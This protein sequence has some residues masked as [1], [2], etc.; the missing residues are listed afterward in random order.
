[1][2]TPSL[3]LAGNHI[4]A[5]LDT[6]A[7]LALTVL[8]MFAAGASGKADE[9]C[10]IRHGS[11]QVVCTA[12]LKSRH[13]DSPARCYG[14]PW[15]PIDSPNATQLHQNTSAKVR[16]RRM[17]AAPAWQ[18]IELLAG[19]VSECIEIVTAP[20]QASRPAASLQLGSPRSYCIVTF[21]NRA[22]PPSLS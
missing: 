10:A 7:I 9:R 17:R 1:M 21:S 20:R 6:G 15:K 18:R 14:S 13:A 2:N 4:K 5:T 11:L 22:P 3:G 19:P 16:S 12:R 8:A